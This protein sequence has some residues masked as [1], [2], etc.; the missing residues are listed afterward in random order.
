MGIKKQISGF[1]FKVKKIYNDLTPKN[2]FIVLFII[3]VILFLI[4][5]FFSFNSKNEVDYKN[6]DSSIEYVMMNRVTDNNLYVTLVSISKDFLNKSSKYENNKLIS[7]KEI[8]NSILSPEYI[9]YLSRRKFE[10][11]YKNSIEKS[12]LIKSINGELIPENVVGN[13]DGKYLLKYTC[14]S[15]DKDTILYVGIQLNTTY[16]KYYVWYLE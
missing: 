12:N 15:G 13:S 16:N 7:I 11:V 2:K 14:K 3:L 9:K 6:F 5:K 8:Y 1:I 10:K 4:V